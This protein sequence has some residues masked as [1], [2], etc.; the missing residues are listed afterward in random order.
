MSVKKLLLAAS[1]LG[2]AACLPAAA[3]APEAARTIRLNQVLILQ[4][5]P[6]LAVLP[7]ASRK[8][9][10]WRLVNRSGATVA[11]GRTSVFGADAGSG[12]H[13]HRIDFSS[14]SGSGEGFRLLAAG[15]E[16]RPFRIG[17]DYA[18][19]AK[20]ALAYFYHNRAGTPILAKHVGAQ[21]ARPAGHVG[22][23]AT[24]IGGKDDKGGNW[25]SCG[26]T[27]DVA[28]GWYDAGDHGKYVVNG[29]IS[30]WTLQNLA[31]RR[32]GALFADGAAQIPE[33]GNKIND[34]LD[35]TRW[36]MEFML[37]MQVPQGTR[38]RLPVGQKK[39]GPGLKFTEVDASG[40]A[41]HKVGDEKWTGLPMA[42]ENDR[43]KRMLFPP[44]TGATLNLAATAAQCARLWKR[45]DPAFSARCL[46]AAERAYAAALR[47]PE[48]YAVADF[49]G[50]GAYGDPD[51]SDE[52]FWAAAE[53]LNTTGRAEYRD[54]VRRS[55]HFRV[56]QAGEFG[57]PT[58]ATL[59]TITLATADLG[60]Q[61][62]ER[63]AQ[64][65]SLLAAADA[66]SGDV[67]KTGYALPY[68][69]QSWPWGS[70]SSILNRAMVLA[71][72]HDFT[73]QKRYRDAVV[74]AMDF[75]LGRNPLDTSF[76]TGYG[77]RP[78]RNPHHRFWAR[79]LDAKYPGPPPGAI[80]G[81]PNNSSLG[82][83]AAA[84]IGGPCAPQTCWVDDI[85]EFTVNEVAVNWNAPLV[86]VSAWLAEEKR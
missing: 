35:E 27:R 20:D 70:T 44:A 82:K 49:T 21:W 85:H 36:Q 25:P 73:G 53:L 77:A 79:Q 32:E 40:M 65:R 16:S 2:A 83:D 9:L 15:A 47:N 58:V 57:W 45:I 37:K 67:A 7:N 34:L 22:E 13:V 63:E 11:S 10:A 3:P 50:S 6:K 14:F 31:E 42:P 78:M 76:V 64:R 30:L 24:C 17:G 51:V 86:W 33:A 26:Y 29:G 75:L 72:A 71:V 59:G 28:G 54:A 18:P 68:A 69:T 19:L 66:W 56:A 52:F 1:A 8:P 80:S 55:P 84:K 41:H 4:D 60:L 43:E 81:G 12:E 48:I 74:D 46:A 23:T 5:G 38:M 61:A 39:S 62:G